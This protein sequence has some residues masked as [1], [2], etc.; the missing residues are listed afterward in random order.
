MPPKDSLKPLAV[1]PTGKLSPATPVREPIAVAPEPVE[2]ADSVADWVAEHPEDKPFKE[3]APAAKSSSDSVVEDKTKKEPPAATPTEHKPSEP[4]P[5]APKPGEAAPAKTEPAPKIEPAVPAAKTYEPQ[6][7]IA[8]AEGSEWTREQIV[9]GLTERAKLQADLKTYEPIKA[10]A[11]GFKQI[12]GMSASEAKTAWG[13]ILSRLAQE[14]QTADFLDSYLQD[15]ALAEYLN[16]C[17]VHFAQQVPAARQPQRQPQKPPVDPVMQQQLKELQ[18][19]KGAQEKRSADDRVRNEW[20]QATSRYPFLAHDQA[21]KQ[22]L[23][24][25]AQW[26]WSQDPSKGILDAL[27]LKAP[28][29]DRIGQLN[30]PAAE[31]KPQPVVPQLLGSQGAS[32]TATRTNNNRPR[33]FGVDDDPV[34]DW[35]DNPPAQYAG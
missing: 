11:E 29:Y 30:A 24:A 4:T 25:T 34:K 32:P 10:E 35:L 5:A 20:A 8:L 1:D 27:A 13:P 9:A 16:E 14:P 21:A 28:V 19:W 6:E 26:M 33:K 22:D 15:P 2:K 23:L 31:P 12:F 7:R 3:E 18:E 17:A